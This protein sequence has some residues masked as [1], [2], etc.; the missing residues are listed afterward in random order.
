MYLSRFFITNI[1]RVIEET[2][3]EVN[4]YFEGETDPEALAERD[5]KLDS[6]A[7]Y[8]LLFDVMGFKQ[9]CLVMV[10]PCFNDE[11]IPPSD[12]SAFL[13]E[14]DVCSELQLILDA[15]SVHTVH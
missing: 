6:L 14:T 12:F 7:E 4:E 13:C 2:R 3:C 5:S 8:D 10:F 1:N 9:P 15:E 11:L